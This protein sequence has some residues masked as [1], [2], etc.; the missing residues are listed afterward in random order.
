MAQ[1]QSAIALI[2]AAL[3][4]QLDGIGD[5]SAKIA[6]E[7]AKTRPVTIFTGTDAE[8]DSI[9]GVE[10]LPTFAPGEAKSVHSLI[11]PIAARRFDWVLL[12]YNPFSYGR[13]GWNPYLAGVLS[14]L[15]KA[16]PRTRIAIMAH[17]TFVPVES[18]PF[19]IMAVYQRAQYYAIGRQADVMFLPVEKWAN[20]FQQ[21][22]PRIP[23]RHLPVGSNLS[24][25]PV[26][27]DE[28]RRRLGIGSET[29]VV[30]VFGTAH[31]SRM[32][33]W[34]GAAMDAIR[35]ENSDSL[36]LYIGPNN[37]AVKAAISAET[38]LCADGPFPAEEA[39]RRFAAMDIA[40]SPYLDG[41]STRR[42]AFM[43]GI[44]HG[45]PTVGTRGIHTDSILLDHEGE[46]WLL[47]PATDEIAF[48][49]SVLTL[50]KDSERRTA[51]GIN[52]RAL[53]YE[54]FDWEAVCR[55]LSE[56]LSRVPA[57]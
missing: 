51:M 8:H 7:L 32:F 52:A 28:A 25:V 31:P 54:N 42:G 9:P 49:T 46:G 37:D 20:K 43:A 56:T 53:Y 18:L 47:P 27:R 5:Y 15:Q 3:P 48:M 40:L 1:N 24:V 57:R 13:R 12:Q 26:Q 11:A 50:L 45:I 21:W 2:A 17:E 36:L 34:V 6:A 55:T 29:F 41:V 23:V 14:Q 39:S 19:A 16:S 10:I 35:R 4:P 22:F 38:P 44:Q 30:G 33:P